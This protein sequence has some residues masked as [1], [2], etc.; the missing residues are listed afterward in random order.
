MS[1]PFDELKKTALYAAHRKLGARL[2][3]F[4][5]WH[6]PVQYTGI[7]DEHNAVRQAAG[8]FDISHMGEFF[9]QGGNATPF[10]NGLLTNDAGKLAMGQGQYTLML[11]EQGGVIDD[12]ILYQISAGQYFL[13]V[14]A[15]KIEE[16]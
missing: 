16:D 11:N 14:N 5:G 9:V 7:V 13:V 12:L 10:L 15:A 8:L 6:M 2:V 4:G 1:V 3:E